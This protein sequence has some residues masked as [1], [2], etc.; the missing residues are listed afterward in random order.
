MMPVLPYFYASIATDQSMIA[1]VPTIRCIGMRTIRTV[2][3][4]A[5]TPWVI[6]VP[7]VVIVIPGV[8][9]DVGVVVVDDGG[10]AASAVGHDSAECE[11]ATTDR[12]ADRNAGAKLIPAASPTGAEYIGTTTGAP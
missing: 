7:V 6:S 8:V 12:F 5:G 9:V 2:T 10:T 4:R 3:V 1:I 11:P